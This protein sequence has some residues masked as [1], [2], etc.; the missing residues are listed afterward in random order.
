MK[1][2]VKFYSNV[3]KFCPIFFAY[4]CSI[5]ILNIIFINNEAINNVIYKTS[6]YLPSRYICLIE[7]SW[8]PITI[9]NLIILSFILKAPICFISHV[10]KF[11]FKLFPHYLN[12]IVHKHECFKR[13]IWAAFLRRSLWL[14]ALVTGSKYSIFVKT[15][16]K[17]LEF[18][19][20]ICD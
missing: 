3:Y 19:S 10:N 13:K 4:V 5:S 20:E 16:V 17:N 12:K 6:Y 15:K 2:L 14:K 8:I 9:A 7:Y 11:H 1:I 18:F